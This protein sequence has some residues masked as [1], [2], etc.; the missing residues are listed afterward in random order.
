MQRITKRG[1]DWTKT[2][3]IDN[4]NLYLPFLM[5]GFGRAKIQ[6][7]SLN[8]LAQ[9]LK[10]STPMR[11]LDLAC[12]IGGHSIYLAK[13]G[14][15][16]VGFD[17]SKFYIN[18]ARILAEQHLGQKHEIRFISGSMHDAGKTLLKNG[19]KRF[20][21]IIL[22]GQSLGFGSIDADIRLFRS[23]LPLSRNK[24]YLFIE[25]Q[26]LFWVLKNF[27][28][29]LFYSFNN[30]EIYENWK[31]DVENSLFLNRS[32]FYERKTTTGDLKLILDI[33]MP[34][35]FYSPHE[36]KVL[37]KA[38][39]WTFVNCY[40]G[41]QERLSVNTDSMMPLAVSRNGRRIH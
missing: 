29:N 30:M 28:P 25:F 36:L 14:H 33:K 11:I 10:I 31:F 19:E 22:M 8:L 26:N 4:P 12:G 18:K 20:D 40:N 35:R 23:L 39:G 3:F 2:L 15:T 16:V 27:Q 5:E 21:L 37:M 13:M 1:K 41:I 17:P 9:E 38:S 34:Q 32:K 6:A 24:T 7:K